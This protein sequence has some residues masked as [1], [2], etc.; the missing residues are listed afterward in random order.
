MAFCFDEA[1]LYIATMLEEV[2]DKGN[3]VNEAVFEDAPKKDNGELLDWMKQH[4]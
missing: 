1:C 2:D 3:P 4:S